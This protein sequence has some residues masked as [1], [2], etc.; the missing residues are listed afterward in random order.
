MFWRR[1][2]SDIGRSYIEVQSVGC[3]LLNRVKNILPAGLID[4]DAVRCGDMGTRHA[5][6]IG[7]DLA[8]DSRGETLRVTGRSP[9]SAVRRSS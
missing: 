8:G 5:L 6:I 4:A 3:G 1:A 9:H 2:E 7:A